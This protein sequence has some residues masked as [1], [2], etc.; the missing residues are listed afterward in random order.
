MRAASLTLWASSPARTG[1]DVPMGGC[2]TPGGT[3]DAFC[4]SFQVLLRFRRGQAPSAFRSVR[5]DEQDLHLDDPCLVYWTD[6]DTL[7]RAR[8]S[9]LQKYTFARYQLLCQ[10]ISEPW[11]PAGAL[12]TL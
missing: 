2:A 6:C 7:W 9:R 1:P 11:Q 8:A 5:R 12:L 10:S 4:A 3:A